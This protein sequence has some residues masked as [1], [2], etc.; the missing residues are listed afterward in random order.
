MIANLEAFRIALNSIPFA[1]LL[2]LIFVYN[3]S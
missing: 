2:V 1:R 3:S